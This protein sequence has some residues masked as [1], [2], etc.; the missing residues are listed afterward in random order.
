MGKIARARY[1]TLE[2][3]CSLMPA[4]A[5][6]VLIPSN[7]N[8]YSLGSCAIQLH[9][10]DKIKARLGNFVRVRQTLLRRVMGSLPR[11][12]PHL[13]HLHHHQREEDHEDTSGRDELSASA[14]T[15]TMAGG[16]GR[17]A[18][19]AL[20]RVTNLGKRRQRL[21][22]PPCSMASP[23]HEGTNE[24]HADASVAVDGKPV[25]RGNSNGN[26]I[27]GGAGG[28]MMPDLPRCERENG[29]VNNAGGRAF[30]GSGKNAMRRVAPSVSPFAAFSST[31]AVASGDD[32]D[33]GG[34][35]KVLRKVASSINT[36]AS[37]LDPRNLVHSS[38]ALRSRLSGGGGNGEVHRAEDHSDLGGHEGEADGEDRPKGTVELQML[39]FGAPRVGNSIYAARYNDVVP[40]S[41]R[42]VVDGDPVPVSGLFLSLRAC[43]SLTHSLTHVPSC[44]V[45]LCPLSRRWFGHEQKRRRTGTYFPAVLIKNYLKQKTYRALHA[46]IILTCL[47]KLQETPLAIPVIHRFR[48]CPAGGTG[49]WG[50]R[51]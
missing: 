19:H 18:S 32:S 50:Q 51:F 1:S 9:T 13:R 48:E 34:G 10:I 41:F 7:H 39:S 3:T 17:G 24:G 30:G 49:T 31:A 42:V 47:P 16:G 28:R 29:A 38:P 21:G 27:D 26:A 15:M 33:A 6:S 20:K 23:L 43:R 12:L 11:R 40:H 8:K 4:I 36:V 37:A 46:C 44:G 25:G 22:S 35:A 5:I 14:G 2:G 45:G